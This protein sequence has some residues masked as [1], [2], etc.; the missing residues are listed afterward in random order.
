[1]AS[2]TLYPPV[3]ENYIPAFLLEDQKITIQFSLS[4]LNS[5][6][7]FT[8]VHAVVYDAKAGKSIVNLSDGEGH[9]RKTG[10]ILNLAYRDLGD[11]LY[12]VDIL[13]E[14]ILSS[15][16]NNAGLNY[17]IQLRLSTMNYD[18]DSGV[19]QADWINA[20]AGAFSEWSSAIYT[21]S[22]AKIDYQ[23]NLIDQYELVYPS[24]FLILNGEFNII[25]SSEIVKECYFVLYDFYGNELE[26]SETLV[27]ENTRNFYYEF[28]TELENSI[29]YKLRFYYI[30]NNLYEGGF[31][32]TSFLVQYNEITPIYY[33]LKTL[34]DGIQGTNLI[35]E[36]EEGY[37]ALKIKPTGNNY[38]G[39]EE[40]QYYEINIRR[41]D[42]EHFFKKWITIKQIKGTI[43][44][45]EKLPIIIDNTIESQVFYQYKLQVTKI[46][47]D[48]DVI[49]P[50]FGA[51]QKIARTFDHTYLLGDKRQLKLKFNTNISNFNYQVVESK[52]DPLGSKYPIVTRNGATYYRTFPING[53]I[54]FQL[55][56]QELFYTQDELYGNSDIKQLYKD[57]YYPGQT[58]DKIYNDMYDIFYEKKFREKVI[59]FLYDG[60][61][62]LFK[63]PTEGN[64]LVRL[65]NVSF[66]PNQTLGR[67][68]YTFSCT[69]YEIGEINMESLL[70]NNIINY[71]YDENSIIP[72]PEPTPI[73]DPD[74]RED[75]D[76]LET[77]LKIID[78][79]D[80][81]ETYDI[82]ILV[83]ETT[84]T[85][86]FGGE[87]QVID[88][89]NIVYHNIDSF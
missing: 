87:I 80:K 11:N 22:I 20:N 19:G 4:N 14:D 15:A 55:D 17:K 61:I 2:Y 21:K 66:A 75:H 54:S 77:T 42:S 41:S 57:K 7:Y 10:I 56:E 38:P 9:Y 85:E 88:A 49:S 67:M 51:T 84:P 48:E 81:Q 64:I 30:T 53:L 44:T 63:S 16:W 45:I 78:S 65:M 35:T 37:I 76:P 31:E 58:S 8:S 29:Y 6:N 27:L 50:S 59:Q 62:K 68:I 74:Y 33:A 18:P 71:V 40:E 72:D 60:K 32:L 89:D 13:K 12:E 52:I 69:A 26:R 70:S 82:K 46:N 47:Q 83:T 39:L 34:E 24:N 79:G 73:P 3:V 36:E 86:T 1:M 25:P 5:L 23:L 28:E 43:D